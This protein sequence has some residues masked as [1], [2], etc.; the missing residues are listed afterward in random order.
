MSYF[1]ATLSALSIVAGVVPQSCST[2]SASL[3][4]QCH[5]RKRTSCSLS[6]H[7]P[8]RTWSSRPMGSLSFPLPVKPKLRGTPSVA[9]I[10]VRMYVCEGV[11]VVAFVP[12]AG[13]VPPPT[14][15]VWNKV[16]Q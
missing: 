9:A 1:S 16:N 10:I 15:V 12:A 13:P 7:A 3:P 6:P 2:S 5:A 11:Q 4:L 8:K 14:R